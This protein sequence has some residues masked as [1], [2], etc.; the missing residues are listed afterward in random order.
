MRK[1]IDVHHNRAR[2]TG[3]RIVHA[4][5]F[6]SIPSD[7]GVLLLQHE[8][9]R[10]HAVPC[11]EI[12]LGVREFRGAFS[13]GTIAS[14]LNMLDEAE[15][16]PTIQSILEDPYAL[17]PE[18][19]RHG[20]DGP[21]RAVPVYDSD[22]EAWMAPFVMALINTRVVRR[23]NALL[24]FAYGRDFRYEEGM[25]MPFGP[26]G[27]PL[28]AGVSAGS[29]AFTAAASLGAIRRGLSRL[30]AQPGEGPS[31]RIRESGRYVIEM[32]GHHPRD[33]SGNLK[34]TIRGDQDPGYGSTSRML[35]EAA[36]C[37]AK[38]PLDS[39]GGVSTPA[40]SMGEVLIDRL[41][42]HAGLSFEVTDSDGTK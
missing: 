31:R 5:G 22:F 12:K 8:M 36:V 18:G 16:D 33:P 39:P 37:L 41:Q 15:R 40:A 29:A 28:A 20:P 35:G 24:D 23:S 14:M 38:D 42:L 34:A 19:E 3:A 30:F 17:N 6:D 13:G 21:D 2:E 25:L 4:C 9:R 11:Q 7:L 1:M 32:L 26:L 27:F 10:R